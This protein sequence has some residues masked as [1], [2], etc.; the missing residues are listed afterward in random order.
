MTASPSRSALVSSRFP[1]LENTRFVAGQGRFIADLELPGML[2]LAVL[3]APYAHAR[4]LKID[5]SAALA[6]PGVLRVITGAELAEHLNP[7]PQNLDLPQV[8]WFPLA[9]DKVR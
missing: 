9:V 7:I 8:R 5:P 3:S 2:H 6:M 1:P 4:I